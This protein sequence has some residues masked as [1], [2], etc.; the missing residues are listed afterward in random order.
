[1][2]FWRKCASRNTASRAEKQ[3]CSLF[4][5][6]ACKQNNLWVLYSWKES[7]ETKGFS[8]T[9]ADA[10]LLLI[11]VH[12]VVSHDLEKDGKVDI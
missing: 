6:A 11:V 9:F 4:E 5:Q 3:S 10:P 8:I 2:K 7:G 12:S 1:M